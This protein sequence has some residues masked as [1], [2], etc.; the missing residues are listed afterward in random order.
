MKSYKYVARDST[1]T[2]KKGLVQAASSNDVLNYLRE[3]GL[4][5]ISINET[6]S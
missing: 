2:Q 1:G 5:P 3:Q 4:T 6:S